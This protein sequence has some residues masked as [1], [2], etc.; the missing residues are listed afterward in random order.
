MHLAAG[1]VEDSVI[2]FGKHRGGC[3]ATAVVRVGTIASTGVG[4]SD[5][6]FV[7]VEARVRNLDSGEECNSVKEVLL[8]ME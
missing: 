4:R 7:K 2:A 1:F 8:A 3:K 5:S 6:G